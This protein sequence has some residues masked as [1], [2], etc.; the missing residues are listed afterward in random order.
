M[1]EEE[2]YNLFSKCRSLGQPHHL[3][4]VSV[5]VRVGPW[6]EPWLCEGFERRRIRSRG[7]SE[8]RSSKGNVADASRFV[9]DTTCTMRCYLRFQRIF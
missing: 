3:N 4:H 1:F 9:F 2:A 6:V 5:R 7:T 8:L